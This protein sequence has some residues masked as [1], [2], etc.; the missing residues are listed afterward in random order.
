MGE[1]IKIRELKESAHG[2][3]FRQI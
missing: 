3:N 1:I 2:T